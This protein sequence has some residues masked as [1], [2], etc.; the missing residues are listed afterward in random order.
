MHMKIR[1]NLQCFFLLPVG[2]FYPVIANVT[3]STCILCLSLQL[4][5]VQWAINESDNETIFMQKNKIFNL[6][7]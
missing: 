2:T 5:S 6:E 3:L 4:A 1:Q 7:F